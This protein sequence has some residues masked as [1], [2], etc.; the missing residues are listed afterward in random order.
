MP[1]RLQFA[2]REE[3]AQA[4]YISSANSYKPFLELAFSVYPATLSL[5]LTLLPRKQGNLTELLPF[6]LRRQL[7][8]QGYAYSCVVREVLW[9]VRTPLVRL[10][11]SMELRQELIVP[12]SRL[13]M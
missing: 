12:M 9:T 6:T 7:G 2:Y 10:G 1:A 8:L 11:P 5:P 13:K 4:L 3:K